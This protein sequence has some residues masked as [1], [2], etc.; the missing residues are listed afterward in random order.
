VSVE[1]RLVEN[2][3]EL[4]RAW[5]KNRKTSMREIADHLLSRIRENCPESKKHRG[6]G[7]KMKDS[8]YAE[9][10]KEGFVIKSKYYR[11]EAITSLE[12]GSAGGVVV[13][14][15]GRAL[16]IPFDA[17]ERPG[18]RPSPKE[19]R[20][21]CWIVTNP[22]TSRITLPPKAPRRFLL[23][24]IQETVKEVERQ[25]EESWFKA[26]MKTGIRRLRGLFRR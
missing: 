18:V 23:R 12:Y 5:K 1:I 26:L 6:P 3:D 24:S 15:P 8:F 4:I 2:T 10:D 19:L 17:W 7:P 20:E 14:R 16:R 21:G 22:P 11:P 9:F 25:V 13:I